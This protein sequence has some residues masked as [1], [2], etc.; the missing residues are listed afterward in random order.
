MDEILDGKG[1]GPAETNRSPSSFTLTLSFVEL[2]FAPSMTADIS[3]TTLK[4]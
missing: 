3:S 1:Q 2:C 4:K